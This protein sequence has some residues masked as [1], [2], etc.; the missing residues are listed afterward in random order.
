MKNILEAPFIKDIS[1]TA[2]NMYRLGWNERNGGNISMILDESELVGYL[3]LTRSLREIP[4]N[5][6]FPEL[7][8]KYFI[9]TGTGKYFKNIK[10]NPSLNTGI[11]KMSEKGDKM[12]LLWGYDD[13]GTFTSEITLHL[14][15]H[16][17]RLGVDSE[18]KVVIHA[19]P[20]NLISMTHIH[21]IADME[22]SKSLW[23]TCTECIVIFPEGVAVLPWMVSSSDKLGMVSSE[24]FKE[25]RVLIWAMHGITVA[26]ISLDE[27]FGLMETVEKAAEIYI[28][29]VNCKS[30]NAITDDML[31]E[32]C[33]D[34]NLTVKKGWL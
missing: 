2:S 5:V 10:S 28:K 11:L 1:E 17:T 14:G 12:Y 22:F 30:K 6:P 33:K 27:A 15:A 24:K 18:H 3:D 9:I 32:I 7:A 13:G 4:L 16:Q 34:F 23:G 20:T 25:Y 31:R 26:G 8:G 21:E 19:H 29:V